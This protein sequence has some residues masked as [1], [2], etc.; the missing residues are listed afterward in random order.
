METRNE[1]GA[2]VSS[3]VG[4]QAPLGYSNNTPAEL[5]DKMSSNNGL[6][7]MLRQII[8]N[9]SVDH[10]NALVVGDALDN[11]AMMEGRN[12]RRQ[13]VLCS[14]SIHNQWD[15]TLRYTHFW[16]F[17]AD[18]IDL[19]TMFLHITRGYELLNALEEA[20]IESLIRVQEGPRHNL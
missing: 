20:V 12:D 19:I 15:L 3:L 11:T 8:R 5:H 10:Q 17:N 14:L 2:V 18:E 7:A 6:K 13:R 16:G 4:H 1:R 9:V